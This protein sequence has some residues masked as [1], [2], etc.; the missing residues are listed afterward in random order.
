MGQ[1]H[2]TEGENTHRRD[3]RTPQNV[4]AKTFGGRESSESPGRQASRISNCSQ[5]LLGMH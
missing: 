1:R 2:G 5:G 3:F 4:G